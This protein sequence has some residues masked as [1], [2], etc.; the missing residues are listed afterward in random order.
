[1]LNYTLYVYSELILIHYRTA[2][3]KWIEPELRNAPTSKRNLEM[4]G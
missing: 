4:Q 2:Q 3:A 1:M